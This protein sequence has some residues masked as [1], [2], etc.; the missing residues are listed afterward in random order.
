MRRRTLLS[1]TCH[2]YPQLVQAQHNRCVVSW[3]RCAD[4]AH[5]SGGKR[6][7]RH[8]HKTSLSDRKRKELYSNRYL[9]SSF[10]N[11]NGKVKGGLIGLHHYTGADWGGKFV[12]VSKKTWISN[13][14]SLPPNDEIVRTFIHMG[15]DLNSVPTA[16]KDLL[17]D[18]NLPAQYRP[19]EHFVCKVYSQQSTIDALP[20][21]ILRWTL[22]RKR[23]VEGEKLPPSRGTLL[24]HILRANYMSQWD[25]SYITTK[26]V[27]PALEH[28]GRK[29]NS[30]GEYVPV[31]CL[32]E[33]APKAI[34]ELVKCG[35]QGNCDSANCSCLRNGL[36]C[37]ALCICTNY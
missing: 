22:F 24:P 1:P 21:L 6:T 13:Y 20:S 33:R 4:S 16:C 12:G 36:S 15:H 10:S 8:I 5:G 7:F 19:L 28:H 37:T 32:K 9:W 18:G 29:I 11:R 35:C 14:L 31:M 34:L 2:P 3:H 25:K 30:K 26:P 27:L 23:N 17:D